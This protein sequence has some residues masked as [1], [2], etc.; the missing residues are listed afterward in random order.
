MQLMT[1]D[2]AFDPTSVETKNAECE[3]VGEPP[4]ARLRVRTTQ[5]A[6]RPGIILAAAEGRWDLSAYRR[7]EI[8]VHNPTDQEFTVACHVENPEPGDRTGREGATVTVPAHSASTLAIRIQPTPWR[9]DRPLDLIGMRG[10][11]G[12]PGKV[13]PTN[14]ARIFLFVADSSGDTVF[15]IEAPQATGEIRVLDAETFLP[16]V[17][18][19]GQWTQ[20][21]WPG[22][23]RDDNDL[24]SRRLEETGS[25]GAEPGPPEWNEYGGWNTGPQLEA[26]GFF[27]VE[28]YGDVWWLVDPEGRLFWSHGVD[29][30]GWNSPTPVTDRETYFRNLPAEDSPLAAFYGQGSWAPHG[31][32]KDKGAY[33]TFDFSR[34]NLFRKYGEE[35]RDAFSAVTHRR[36][37]GWGLNTIGN[38]SDA[39]I[40]GMQKTPYVV[41]IHYNAPR[42]EGSTGWWG[43]FFDV[44]D[45]RLR[46]TIE[47][48]MSRETHAAGDPWC[49][50][51]FVDNEIS[52]GDDISLA[53]ATLRS[54]A[55]QPAKRV[56]VD[57]LKAKYG[58]IDALNA[59]WGTGHASW[60]ALLESREPPDMGKARDD[61]TAF[62]AKTADTYFRTVRDAV[63][64]VAP[65]QLYLGCRFAWVNDTVARAAAKYCDVVGYNRYAYS[66]ADLRLPD[67]I[68]RPIIIGEFHFGALDRGMFHP[69]LREAESQEHRAALYRDYV[70]GALRNPQ[71][72]GVHWFQYRD[73]PRTG[74][75]DGE[76]YQIG[77]I[78]ICD[79]PYP[80]LVAASREVGASLYETRLG[81]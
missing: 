70:R 67:G 44:F 13:D 40:C 79:T 43:K 3:L 60:E 7:V 52:W 17:D 21:D 57:D 30:V 22:K 37:R 74:R 66:A 35:W 24:A 4:D 59:A 15:E 19:Y 72:V 32:Y 14:V 10:N 26:T 18:E 39:A 36:L 53:V 12:R 46:R 51:F 27:R 54:P 6:E 28:T 71:I 41:A 63:K 25:L 31:Y 69:G 78:D 5:A 16:F 20:G 76:N 64:A 65:Q 61:L 33:R 81:R 75:G 49:I 48:R 50:G 77:F 34:A 38:W 45:P 1:F 47:N 9:F 56:F 58:T 11:P 80:E 68:D 62:Y 2:A 8:V 42:L 29:C 23:T 73:Q 55:E